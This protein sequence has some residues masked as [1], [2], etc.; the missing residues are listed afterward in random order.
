MRNMR[1]TVVIGIIVFTLLVTAAALGKTSNV[2]EADVV[3]TAKMH[4]LQDFH[5]IFW[6]QIREAGHS[7]DRLLA[8]L[9][10][11][12]ALEHPWQWQVPPHRLEYLDSLS[13][14]K[15]FEALYSRTYV[16]ELQRVSSEFAISEKVASLDEERTQ[17]RTN[18]VTVVAV[19]GALVLAIGIVTVLFFIL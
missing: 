11:M 9:D 7:P 6:R 15:Q 1:N 8:I 18:V 4:A 2:L 13:V 16:S 5:E 12:I 19:V 14:D 3:E 10:R 17:E